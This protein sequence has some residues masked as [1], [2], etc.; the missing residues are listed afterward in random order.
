MNLNIESLEEFKARRLEVISALTSDIL[1]DGEAIFIAGDDFE[2]WTYHGVKKAVSSWY[3]SKM[4]LIKYFVDKFGDAWDWAALSVKPYKF[5]ILTPADKEDATTRILGTMKNMI[6][7]NNDFIKSVSLQ[8]QKVI[9]AMFQCLYDQWIKKDSVYIDEE[10]RATLNQLAETFNNNYSSMPKCKKDMTILKYINAFINNSNLIVKELRELMNKTIVTCFDIFKGLSVKY[11]VVVSLHPMAYLCASESDYFQSCYCISDNGS[12]R[13]GTLNYMQDETTALTFTF[14]GDNEICD[15]L[16]RNALARKYLHFSKDGPFLITDEII[17]FGRSYPQQ[18]LNYINEGI[19]KGLASLFNIKYVQQDDT[20]RLIYMDYTRFYGLGYSDLSYGY[21]YNVNG[22]M[23]NDIEG[24]YGKMRN[25]DLEVI[26]GAD[27]P[28]A[29][30][31]GEPLAEESYTINSPADYVYCEDCGERI[32]YEDAYYVDG[33]YYCEDCVEQCDEC[34]EY[35]RRS[36]II[37]LYDGYK[38]CRDCIDN[39]YAVY[40]EDIEDWARDCDATYCEVDGNYYY[41]EDNM[42]KEDDEEEG[43]Y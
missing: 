39:G 19:E 2:E 7:Y 21:T 36:D 28:I 5:E 16:E 38:M 22:V 6:Y 12:Y 1:E 37:E 11:N 15:F 20:T 23:C 40:C 27:N 9:E 41:Y 3:D 14:K 17:L 4:A 34:G 31:D 18:T 30:D 43:D 29:L 10:T 24:A 33:A 35:H 8:N 13:G 26:Y 25:G 32:R 42:P